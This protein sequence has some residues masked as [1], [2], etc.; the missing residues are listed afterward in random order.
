MPQEVRIEDYLNSYRTNG[1]PPTPVPQEPTGEQ[2]RTLLNLPPLFKPYTARDTG[3]AS[4]S[5]SGASA[6]GVL[7]PAPPVISNPE[8]LP[9]VQEF[10]TTT[11]DGEI[12]Q[13]ISVMPQFRGISPEVSAMVARCFPLWA[14][15][16]CSV[17]IF[18]VSQL[19]PA[20]M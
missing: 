11:S 8:V 4:F 15:S 20:G 12:F 19:C 1:R 6:N 10:L 3:P 17:N 7:T 18:L 2:Q 16:L 9:A 14:S 13:H 5:S